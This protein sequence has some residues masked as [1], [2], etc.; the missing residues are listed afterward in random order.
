MQKQ[1]KA[2]IRTAVIVLLLILL[3]ICLRFIGNAGTLP[4]FAGLV[5][6]F[7]YIGILAD[8]TGHEIFHSY[9]FEW[10]PPALV[11]LLYSNALYSAHGAVCSSFP[12]KSRKLSSAQM[13]GRAVYSHSDTRIAGAYQ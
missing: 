11:R 6:S 1:N 10:R 8:D 9:R 4:T 2:L 3:A 7:I 13:D 5:R 12:W